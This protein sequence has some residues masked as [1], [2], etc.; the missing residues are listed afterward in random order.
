MSFLNNVAMKRFT[1]VLLLIVSVVF[2]AMAGIDTSKEYLIKYS[3]GTYLN[4]HNHDTHTSGAFGG[5]NLAALNGSNSQIFIFEESGDGYKLNC[6]VQVMCLDMKARM[7]CLQR[8]P[9]TVSA[10]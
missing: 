5:V 10:L 4:V 7:W 2:T 8:L 6:K 9:L 1:S 3:D